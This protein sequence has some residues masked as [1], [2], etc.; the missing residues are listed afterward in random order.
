MSIKK[1]NKRKNQFAWSL[2]GDHNKYRKWRSENKIFKNYEQILIG[3]MNVIVVVNYKLV[4]RGKSNIYIDIQAMEKLLS[5]NVMEKYRSY[6][7]DI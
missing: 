1:V 5:I 3:K 2:G 6:K 7:T 4:E